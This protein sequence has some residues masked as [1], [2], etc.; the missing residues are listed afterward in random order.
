MT[1]EIEPQKKDEE[2]DDEEE[3]EEEEWTEMISP[4]MAKPICA[5]ASA[6]VRYGR[7]TLDSV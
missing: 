7:S 2:Y 3:E 5:C 6:C 4:F 1:S